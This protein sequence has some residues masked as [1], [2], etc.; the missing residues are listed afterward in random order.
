M[1]ALRTCS[2][3]IPTTL[4]VTA[5][6]LPS[7]ATAQMSIPST[8]TDVFSRLLWVQ[9]SAQDTWRG[10]DRGNFGLRAGGALSWGEP[11]AG[12]TTFVLSGEARTA[13]SDRTDVSDL[14]RGG[15]ALAYRIDDDG[16]LVWVGADAFFLPSAH[17]RAETA[18]LAA[19][20]RFAVPAW[21]PER[22]PALLVEARRD[23]S[24]YQATY[25]RSALRLD[26]KFGVQN[27]AMIEVGQSWSGLPS[28]DAVGSM[29]F[30]SQGTDLTLTFLRQSDPAR[31]NAWTNLSIEPFLRVLWNKRNSD[32]N[33]FDIGL[34]IAFPQ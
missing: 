30:G 20:F 29:G 12:S 5:L 21:L 3:W 6:A 22:H 26:Y 7:V 14:L 8:T 24:R 1:K 17:A 25:L 10:I 16:T 31:A 2:A 23:L 32:R 13:V 4:L 27:G 11:S 9:G 18:E 19:G 15:L 33:L 34:R 28:G